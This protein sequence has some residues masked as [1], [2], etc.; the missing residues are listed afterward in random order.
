MP[1]SSIR[2]HHLPPK[3]A[4]FAR[5]GYRFYVAFGGRG[6]GK[7]STVCTLALLRGLQ[8]P[9]RILCC[10]EVQKSIAQSI[11][12][13]LAGAIERLGLQDQYTVTN[14]AIRGVNG[15]EFVFAGL[16]YNIGSL[17]SYEDIDLVI[18]EEAQSVSRKSWDVLIPTIR[19]PGSEF[20]IVFNPELDTDETYRRFVLS[21][22][23]GTVK[24]EIQYTD[25]P[26]ISKEFI[27]LAEQERERDP[28]S[29]GYIYGGHCRQVVEG[30]VY[31]SELRAATSEGRICH[32]PYDPAKPVHTAWDLGHADNTAIWFFQEAAFELKVIDFYQDRMQPLSHY[33]KML[34]GRGYVYGTHYL[35]H[36]A[37]HKTL[38]AAGRSVRVQVESAGYKAV[39]LK[40]SPVAAGIR[41]VRDIFPLVYFDATRCADG[42]NA[43]KHYRYGVDD[44][45]Q[46]TKE[47]HHNDASHPADAFRQLAVRR[48]QPE[49]IRVNQQVASQGGWMG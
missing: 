30:A 39:S 42:I 18:V 23:A 2:Q 24:V 25:N 19:K 37:E 36:D 14:N 38:A 29:Y 34:Q 33:L 45:G 44:R 40:P 1:V 11:H 3:M 7:T 9:L 8:A 28:V 43:L 31:A 17:R 41:A 20:W 32:V 49:K 26:F 5:R 6:G 12:Q 27:S 22:P 16:K 35:P 13:A 21:P 4:P 47:P 46:Y 10:R 15:T 48:A